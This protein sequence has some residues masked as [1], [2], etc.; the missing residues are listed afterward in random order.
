MAGGEGSPSSSPITVAAEAICIYYANR[1]L[2]LRSH[3][4]SRPLVGPGG[5]GEGEYIMLIRRLLRE[6]GGP[7][8][9]A[10]AHCLTHEHPGVFK[11]RTR[12]AAELLLGPC[13]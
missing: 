5:P 1:D 8:L 13:G 3:P 7:V 10:R 11:A 4:R 12:E 9:E 6:G 2:P